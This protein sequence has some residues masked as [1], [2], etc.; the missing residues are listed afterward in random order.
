MLEE[1]ESPLSGPGAISPSPSL[2]VGKNVAVFRYEGS[3]ADRLP[4]AHPPADVRVSV[5]YACARF[6]SRSFLVRLPPHRD[7]H[8]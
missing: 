5:V 1:D 2:C 7:R 6:F 3:F 4:I 8:F